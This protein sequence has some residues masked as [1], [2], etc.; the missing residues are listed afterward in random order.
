MVA[1]CIRFEMWD[2]LLLQIGMLSH[3][4]NTSA[5]GNLS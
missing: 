1:C 5:A 3:I 2:L 4:V